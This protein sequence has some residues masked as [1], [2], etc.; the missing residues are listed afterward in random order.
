MPRAAEILADVDGRVL[1]PDRAPD[2]VKEPEARAG[3]PRVGRVFP[4]SVLDLRKPPR[5]DRN[6]LGVVLLGE[7]L[8]ERS[9]GVPVR[10]D[11]GRRGL[12]DAGGPRRSARRA[13]TRSAARPASPATVTTFCPAGTRAFALSTAREG[14]HEILRR[15]DVR[16]HLGVPGHLLDVVRPVPEGREVRRPTCS[17]R[18][19]KATAA[20]ADAREGPAAFLPE[21]RDA[22]RRRGS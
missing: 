1:R 5:A 22:D 11:D 14:A 15:L 9:L 18:S 13:G 6:A 17:R 8:L 2:L 12:L 7:L 4:P 16:Q 10:D 19:R 3:P 20:S 21:P